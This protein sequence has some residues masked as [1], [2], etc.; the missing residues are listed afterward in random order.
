MCRFFKALHRELQACELLFLGQPVL[1]IFLGSFTELFMS[2]CI[3]N[4]HEIFI[5]W[6]IL[7]RY[8]LNC[9]RI[10]VYIPR[11]V[12]RIL[13]SCPYV[14]CQFSWGCAGMSSHVCLARSRSWWSR[15][16]T[17][18][19]GVPFALPYLCLAA[20]GS[21]C[22]GVLATLPSCMH[23]PARL[24]TPAMPS[25]HSI[26]TSSLGAQG[27]SRARLC[28]QVLCEW[29]T[30]CLPLPLCRASYWALWPGMHMPCACICCLLVVALVS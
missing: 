28:L 27:W 6:V 1:R 3:Y 8:L 19:Y 16:C 18:S 21:G 13:L 4:L 25:R 2:M 10:R 7:L 30:S 29:R 23:A 20:L 22:R 9:S 26:F 11:M 5:F 24:H 14:S 15:S 12:V 17:F